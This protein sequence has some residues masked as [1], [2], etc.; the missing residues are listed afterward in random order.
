MS[1]MSPLPGFSLARRLRAGETVFTGWCPL[2][3]PI[4]AETLAREGFST[5]T[6]DQQHGLWDTAA[7]VTGIA[8]VR[9]GGAA[10]VVRIPLGAFDVGS[11]VLDMGAEGVIAPMINTAADARAFVSAAKFPPLGERSWGPQ[12][13][14]TLAGVPDMKAYLRDAN[15][16][17][18]TLAMIETR[19]AMDNLDIIAGTPG[20]DVLFVGPS[21]LSIGLS[22]GAELDP[23]SAVIDAALDR[24]VATA[25]KAGKIAGLYCANAQR[26]MACAKRGIRFLAVGS[27]LAFLRA[28]AGAELKILKG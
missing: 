8:A 17:V 16:N 9:A 27:D 1:P 20:I 21:D 7:T 12:R 26:A 10:P 18:V 13:A 4:V 19:T 23:H 24:I 3:A 22:N 11:R 28:G 2:G 25:N 5:V 6:L 14:M 15:E